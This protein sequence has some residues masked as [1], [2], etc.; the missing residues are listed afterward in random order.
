MKNPSFGRNIFAFFFQPPEAVVANQRVRQSKVSRQLYNCRFSTEDQMSSPWPVHPGNVCCFF[1]G[2]YFRVSYNPELFHKPIFKDPVINQP[3]FH[4]SCHCWVL[5]T[6]QLGSLEKTV[7]WEKIM[8]S[9]RKE[10]HGILVFQHTLMLR[11]PHI[12]WDFIP[13]K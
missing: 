1:W 11:Y 8:L 13:S 4:Y 12:W 6:A 5:I 3:G 2:W 10:M 9:F 7:P